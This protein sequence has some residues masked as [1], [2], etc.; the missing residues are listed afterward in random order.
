MVDQKNKKLLKYEKPVLID[1][2]LEV[3][4]GGDKKC[5][6][7]S[8]ATLG[9]CQ[10]GHSAQKKCQTGYSAQGEC[11]KVGLSAR[12]GCNKGDAGAG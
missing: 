4:R 1:F 10:T 11:K 3:G 7:G 12:G 5:T 9:K 6:P 8:S 2:Q